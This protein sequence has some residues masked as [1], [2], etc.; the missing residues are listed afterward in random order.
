MTSESLSPLLIALQE[1]T[2]KVNQLS[3][4]IRAL[5]IRLAAM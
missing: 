3:L 4:E 1:E 5:T 2:A